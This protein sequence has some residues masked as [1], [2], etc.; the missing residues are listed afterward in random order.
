MSK[1]KYSSEFK[2]MIAEGID[3]EDFGYNAALH[4]D[5]KLAGWNR[6]YRN[7]LTATASRSICR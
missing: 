3:K 1:P 7:Y 5:G 4:E 2:I 6:A